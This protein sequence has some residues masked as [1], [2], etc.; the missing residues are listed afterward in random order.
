MHRIDGHGPGTAPVSVGLAIGSAL[1]LLLRAHG[2]L[3]VKKPVAEVYCRELTADAGFDLV[4]EYTPEGGDV[5]KLLL[6]G[7]QWMVE[8][9][10]IDFDERLAL[11]GSPPAT[12][13]CASGG[14]TRIRG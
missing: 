7:D 6:R 1:L 8:G 9:Y 13:W 4:M 14:G 2:S 5:R 3:D 11:W 10:V 12:G